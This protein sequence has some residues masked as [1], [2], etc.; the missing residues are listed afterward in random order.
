M[1]N[2]RRRMRVGKGSREIV[3]SRLIRALEFSICD[4]CRLGLSLPSPTAEQGAS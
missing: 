2:P 1:R 3:L 4:A